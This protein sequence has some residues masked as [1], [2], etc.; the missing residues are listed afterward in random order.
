MP[1]SVPFSSNMASATI[2]SVGDESSDPPHLHLRPNRRNRLRQSRPVCRLRLCLPGR[3][4]L[5]T[6]INSSPL[7][8]PGLRQWFRST[9]WRPDGTSR[10]LSMDASVPTRPCFG[11][12][13]SH[14]DDKPLYLSRESMCDPSE[15][16]ILAHLSF[17]SPL[18]LSPRVKASSGSARARPWSDYN[19]WISSLRS[20]ICQ[21]QFGNER[22]A[23]QWDA[24][25]LEQP[26]RHEDTSKSAKQPS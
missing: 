13:R 4:S 10:A 1:W 2:A 8:R 18:S 5:A 14:N 11:R 20:V 12:R 23:S 25:V 9:L 15:P 24:P 7:S 26:P 3:C 19:C 16:P 17:L 21:V 22:E 6:A